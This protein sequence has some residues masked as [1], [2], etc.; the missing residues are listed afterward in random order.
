MK[1]FLSL[2]ILLATSFS[3]VQQSHATSPSWCGNFAVHGGTLI[4][5]DG[6]G[7]RISHGDIGVSPGILIAGQFILDGG[8]TVDDSSEFAER[9]KRNHAEKTSQRNGYTDMG[10][11][12]EIGGQTFTPG[13]YRF[14]TGIK[15]GTA[16]AKVILDGQGDQNAEFLFQA[17][18]SFS[19]AT[20]T[21][22]DLVNGAKAENII[23]AL[24]TVAMLGIGSVVEGSILA[25]T[26]IMFETGS[27]LHGC[28]IAQTMV[29]FRTGGIVDLNPG[30]V[31]PNLGNVVD[32]NPDV[33]VDLNP[34]IVVDP[35]PGIVVDPN[36]GIVVDPNPGIVVDPNPAS[37]SDVCIGSTKTIMETI[38]GSYNDKD[39]TWQAVTAVTITDDFTTNEFNNIKYRNACEDDDGKYEE[40]TYEA[41]CKPTGGDEITL[42]VIG[43][44]RCYA[45]SCSAAIESD[46]EFAN[47]LF[48]EFTLKPT[49]ERANEKHDSKSLGWTC[50]GELNDALT[51]TNA[52]SG[53]G[54]CGVVTGTTNMAMKPVVTDKKLLFLFPSEEKKVEYS[55]SPELF[56]ACR[57]VGG[58]LVDEDFKMTCTTG[59]GSD[60]ATFEVIAFRL[61]LASVCKDNEAEIDGAINIQFKDQMFEWKHL[62]EAQD[63]TCIGSGVM[64]TSIRVA[65]GAALA[66]WWHLM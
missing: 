50:T 2:S 64:A 40:L 65:V 6:P 30:I 33:V 54:G 61:C 10:A 48:K 18:S 66:L 42:Q 8:V 14:R 43:Q 52:G 17:G 57:R 24:G 28:A 25:G 38:D 15:L 46:E 62:D 59:D 23:W 35:N 44:P 32:L 34:G 29:S 41:K 53:Y 9:A 19:T 22:F 1:L 39:A 16:N 60:E 26:G 12:S 49:A 47:V 55:T 7:S 31:G 11:V 51:S 37:A 27:E 36:P 56:G 4:N 5:F 45:K 13:T 63:W 20:G 3:K 21:Y 58:L